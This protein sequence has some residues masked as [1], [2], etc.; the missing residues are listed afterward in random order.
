ME[1]WQHQILARMQSARNSQTEMVK[2]QTDTGLLEDSMT[3]SHTSKY[4]LTIWSSNCTSKWLENMATQNSA[5]QC[6]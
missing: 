4:I 5:N 2:M 3:V 1:Y 6:L